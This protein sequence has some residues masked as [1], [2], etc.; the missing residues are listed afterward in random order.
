MWYDRLKG[1]QTS[2]R[3]FQTW[4]DYFPF[5]IWDFILPIDELIFFK[6][7]KTTNQTCFSIEPPRGLSL[8]LRETVFHPA[9]LERKRFHLGADGRPKKGHIE[10]VKNDQV[11]WWKKSIYHLNKGLFIDDFQLLSFPVNTRWFSPPSTPLNG[12]STH[13]EVIADFLRF[14]PA[15]HMNF[16][17]SVSIRNPGESVPFIPIDC[18]LMSPFFVAI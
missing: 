12:W 6:M 10:H 9:I 16:H 8:C 1:K 15:S 5:H 4:M 2:G 18:C 7:V 17:L 11:G 13:P 14:F 3:W